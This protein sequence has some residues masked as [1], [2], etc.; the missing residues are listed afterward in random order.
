MD[1]TARVS[2]SSRRTLLSLLS[3]LSDE[4]AL[5]VEAESIYENYGT[6]AFA[7][8][9][10]GA[11]PAGYTSWTDATGTLRCCAGSIINK[12][13]F[14]DTLDILYTVDPDEV[15]DGDIDAPDAASA[16]SAGASSV[17]NSV[18]TT[19]TMYS[20]TQTGG[21]TGKSSTSSSATK[22]S[23]TLSAT[24]ASISVYVTTTASQSITTGS[25]SGARSM[26]G[27]SNKGLASLGV[28]AV[29]LVAGSMMV[30]M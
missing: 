28:V 3:P 15:L 29:G 12:H 24:G 7:A 10:N 5:A 6:T 14:I 19:T 20:A 22:L 9:T 11:C 17:S 21:T 1:L 23:L 26:R 2:L 16:A 25:T 30:F 18:Q 27:G 8:P 13:C 4:S